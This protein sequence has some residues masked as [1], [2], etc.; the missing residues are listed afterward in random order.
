MPPSVTRLVYKTVI[1]PKFLYAS[2][3]CYPKN[4]NDQIAFEYV[5]KYAA[6][7]ISDRHTG[8][9]DECIA[10]ANLEPIWKISAGRRL[11]LFRAYVDN[12]RFLPNELSS[13]AEAPHRLGLRSSVV[14]PEENQ[15][16]FAP[17]IDSRRQQCARTAL[18][19]MINQWNSLPNSLIQLLYNSFKKSGEII[20]HLI[21]ANLL[22]SLE[23]P[24]RHAK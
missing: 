20:K 11:S 1:Q 9:Y 6:S 15:T 12:M 21:E 13:L 16:K 8:S 17:P 5:N 24:V 10:S 7:L 14:K 18:S 4:K 23:V 2:T 22:I 3:V 19:L